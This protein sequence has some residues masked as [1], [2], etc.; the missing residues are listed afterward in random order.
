[1]SPFISSSPFFAITKTFP[2]PVVIA[3]SYLVILILLVG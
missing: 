2:L 3:L 1:M